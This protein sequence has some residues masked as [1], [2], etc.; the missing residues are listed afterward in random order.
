MEEFRDM[1]YDRNQLLKETKV[2]QEYRKNKLQ[3]PYYDSIPLV[4]HKKAQFKVDSEFVEYVKERVYES[5]LTFG[6][7]LVLNLNSLKMEDLELQLSQL[8]KSGLKVGLLTEGGRT[9]DHSFWES[10]NRLVEL[11]VNNH[12]PIE[13]VPG[14][15]VLTHTL[16]Q[17]GFPSDSF[18]YYGELEGSKISR[19]KQLNTLKKDLQTAIIRATNKSKRDQL[20]LRTL[21]DIVHVYG[22]RQEVFI[23]INVCQEGK[24]RRIRGEVGDMIEVFRD[25]PV[26]E[27]NENIGDEYLIVVAPHTFE[28]NRGKFPKSDILIY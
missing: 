7:G 23:G 13:S 14:T 21:T 6:C 9:L 17:S 3:K 1:S 12:L 20:L 5:K 28:Y 22:A 8:M 24:E 11:S 19:H 4:D 10:K 16:S 27:V 25:D 2:F 15:S 26:Y 18:I